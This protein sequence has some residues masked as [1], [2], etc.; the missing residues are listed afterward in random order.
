MDNS[1]ESAKQVPGEDIK[2]AGEYKVIPKL[3][4]VMAVAVKHSSRMIA[5]QE[6]YF[7]AKECG[8]C[9]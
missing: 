8:V 7:P 2:N 1:A 9:Q 6:L 5:R 4:A 3:L